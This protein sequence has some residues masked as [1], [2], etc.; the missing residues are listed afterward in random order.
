MSNPFIS[1]IPVLRRWADFEHVSPLP[2]DFSDWIKT[3]TT[4]ALQLQKKDPQ[5]YSLLNGTA[6]ASLVADAFSG[7]LPEC[8]TPTEELEEQQKRA[9][10]QK[11]IQENPYQTG[12]LTN[13]LKLERLD[14]KAAAKF[15]EEIHYQKHEEVRETEKVAAE[16]QRQAIE[17]AVAQG[18]LHR[19]QQTAWQ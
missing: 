12:N 1:C 4:R 15:R 16:E 3:N 14:P 7:V 13:V 2:L 10:I 11:L 17:Q 8:P 6:P 18:K 5:L 19:L 9:Q